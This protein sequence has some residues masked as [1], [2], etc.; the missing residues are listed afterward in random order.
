MA[1]LISQLLRNREV[2][3][4]SVKKCFDT[5]DSTDCIFVDDGGENDEPISEKTDELCVDFTDI[6]PYNDLLIIEKRIKEMFLLN[7]LSEQEMKI[8]DA[9]AT[10]K[11]FSDLEE[12]VKLDR[13][14]IAKAFD[15]ITDKVAFYMGDYFTDEGY[16]DYITKKYNLSKDQIKLLEN[17]ISGKYKYKTIRRK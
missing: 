14:N 15:E 4:E 16:I 10:N 11:S 9:V 3:K 17:Y 12:V 13:H 2:I 6:D 7:I 8:I 5:V 1:W